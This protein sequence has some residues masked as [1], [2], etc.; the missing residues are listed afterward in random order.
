MAVSVT[1]GT[2]DKEDVLISLNVKMTLAEWK[3]LHAELLNVGPVSTQLRDG[4][5]SATDS[6]RN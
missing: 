6:V 3:A 1:F 5:K 4:I 2:L